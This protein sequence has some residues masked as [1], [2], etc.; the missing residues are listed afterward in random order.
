MEE[1]PVADGAVVEAV[2][3]AGGGFL[4]DVAS[5][6]C[7]IV[8]SSRIDFEKLISACPKVDS[9]GGGVGSCFSLK[10]VDVLHHALQLSQA[11]QPSTS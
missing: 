9:R 7:A 2:G 1:V 10:D 3:E 4:V 8:K 5:R 6:V 11:P